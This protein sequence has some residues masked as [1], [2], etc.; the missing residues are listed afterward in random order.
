MCSPSLQPVFMTNVI[1][2]FKITKGKNIIVSSGAK[3]Y[4]FVK[5]PAD[6]LCLLMALGWPQQKTYETFR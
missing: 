4:K 3:D 1:N 2:L 5:S 6:I